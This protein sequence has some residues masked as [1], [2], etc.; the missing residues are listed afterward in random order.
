MKKRLAVFALIMCFVFVALSCEGWARE[1]VLSLDVHAELKPDASMVVT[2]R[3]R[4]IIEHDRIRHGLTYAYPIKEKYGDRALRHYGFDLLSVRL[5][6]APV[7]SYQTRTGYAFGLAIGEEG[8]RAPLGE[9]V[10]EISYVTTGHVRFLPERD[11]LYYNVM[12]PDWEFPVDHVSFQLTLP[13]DNAGAF[14][15]TTAYTGAL[16]ESGTDYVRDGLSQVRTT[17]TLI[18]GQGLTVAMAWKKGL[19][20]EPRESLANV[21][22]AHRT[23]VFTGIFIM[24]LAYSVLTRRKFAQTLTGAIVPLFSPPPGMSPGYVAG[25]RSLSYQGRML[26]ADLLWLAVQG[27]IRLDA[28]EKNTLVV[29]PRTDTDTSHGKGSASWAHEQCLALRDQLVPEGV[30]LDLR[31]PSGQA[32]ALK[33]FRYLRKRYAHEQQELWTRNFL[34]GIGGLLLCVGLFSVALQYVYTPVLDLI[35]EQIGSVIYLIIMTSVFVMLTAVAREVWR[36]FFTAGWKQRI[37]SIVVLVNAVSI[38]GF[39]IWSL[40]DNDTE[41]VA[42]LVV[43]LLLTAGCAINPL[44]RFS[45]QGWSE[46]LQ[47]LGLEM[48]IRTAEQERLAVINAPEDTMEKFEELLPYAVALDCA[49][50]WQKRFAPVLATSNYVPG[51]VET[52]D[53]SMHSALT[54]VTSRG[55]GLSAA[56]Q[57]CARA[58]QM[59][60]ARAGFG[61]VGL[62]G[63]GRGSGFGGGSAGRGSG[64]GRAGGW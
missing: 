12:Q 35:P 45:P 51:W 47:V 21:L 60:G 41:F 16:G 23:A 56:S 48:Y 36:S 61:A 3:I 50:A 11:E 18:P 54:L 8:V 38:I 33:A 32:S 30:A 46:R 26:H 62:G 64:G 7:H 34:P 5:D 29:H 14:L 40:S 59:A 42:F 25:I 58:S 55:S 43:S 4:V 13:G 22:G 27:F 2:E 17:R 6:G 31:N 19:I 15:E 28:R 39:F 10:Y 63:F 37:S 9:H 49:Q 52:P 57:A 44:V 53:R 24:I 1:R 20:H